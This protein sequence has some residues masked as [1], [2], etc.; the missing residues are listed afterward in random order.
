[1]QCLALSWTT[2]LREGAATLSQDSSVPTSPELKSS[3]LPMELTTLTSNERMRVSNLPLPNAFQIFLISTPSSGFVNF[4]AKPK[5]TAT[6][7][8]NKSLDSNAFGYRSSK[9][10]AQANISPPAAGPATL[11]TRGSEAVN[12]S[13]RDSNPDPPNALGLRSS[14]QGTR[15]ICKRVDGLSYWFPLA[16][17]CL[18]SGLSC[19]A[20][21]LDTL[22][23]QVDRLLRGTPRHLDQRRL[24]QWPTLPA[25]VTCRSCPPAWTPRHL[26]QRLRAIAADGA[27]ASGH[28]LGLKD[29]RLLFKT[30]SGQ[31]KQLQ[32]LHVLRQV[33]DEL[34]LKTNTTILEIQGY[35]LGAASVRLQ[36][37]LPGR[38]F[39]HPRQQH[40]PWVPLESAHAPNTCVEATAHSQ[41]KPTHE[42]ALL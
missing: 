23:L 11:I 8:E 9:R 41:D 42:R 2:F 39:G 17:R 22:R 36:L 33:T 16:R 34:S 27:F 40:Q 30:D 38:A 14:N 4:A 7:T 5:S 35:R 15:H 18:D 20:T 1:M 3:C 19:I 12:N 32:P 6:F 25:L 37:S 26:D 29:H 13:L 24:R 21:Q 28:V 10:H 31:P